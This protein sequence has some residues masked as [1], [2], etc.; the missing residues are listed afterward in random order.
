RFL[1]SHALL[2]VSLA[3]LLTV[4]DRL[5]SRRDWEVSKA[6]GTLL[7]EDEPPPSLEFGDIRA[8]YEARANVRFD[9]DRFASRAQ[10]VVLLLVEAGGYHT[11]HA[12]G[13]RLLRRVQADLADLDPRS[14]APDLR[15]GFTSD[16]AINTEETEAL[17]TDLSVSS[18]FVVVLVVAVIAAYFEWW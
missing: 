18:V 1:S 2:Y 7:D 4:R 8:R 5:E 13:E 14:Y 15:V 17:L 9:D 3:D 6:Q 16:I 12:Y 11:G 10:H